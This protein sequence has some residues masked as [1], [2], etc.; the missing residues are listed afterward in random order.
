MAAR[1]RCRRRGPRRLARWQGGTSPAR[2]PGR[3]RSAIGRPDRKV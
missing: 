3:R 2:G 1:V